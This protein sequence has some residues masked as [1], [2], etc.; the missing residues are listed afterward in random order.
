M[1]SL[2]AW[3]MRIEAIVGDQGV[4]RGDGDEADESGA[5]VTY[6]WAAEDSQDLRGAAAVVTDCQEAI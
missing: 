1:Y 5:D 6:S 4:V 2:D 3:E